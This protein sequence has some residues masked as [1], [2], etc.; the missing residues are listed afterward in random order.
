MN[1]VSQ[2]ENLT[3]RVQMKI[4]KY[5]P[6][7]VLLQLRR[8]S[9]SQ[10]FRSFRNFVRGSALRYFR[11]NFRFAYAKSKGERFILANGKETYLLST[12]D[13]AISSRLFAEG[14][15]DFY[16][17]ERAFYALGAPRLSTLLDVGAHVGSISIPAVK[18]KFADRAIALE[19]DKENYWLL[20]TNIFLNGLEEEIISIQA[21][22]GPSID[23]V[24]VR[25]DG[26]SN[27]GDHRYV[28]KQLLPD[29]E[30]SA[31]APTILLDDFFGEIDVES[32]LL[33]MDI[34]GGEGLALEGA[35]KLL[36]AG[37]P[38]VLE[39]DPALLEANGGFKRGFGCLS[40]YSSFID[41]GSSVLELHDVGTLQTF[42]SNALAMGTSHDLLF[43]ATV[44]S[45]SV[46]K[47]L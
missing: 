6:K 24:Y 9:F 30:A 19:P 42:Y 40:G 10:N 35:Q 5:R 47:W 18:R 29:H 23:S 34:Q 31:G 32:S 44:G 17:F 4:R 27:T 37:I 43:L 2:I 46:V 45:E 36:E 26:G 33:W 25:L 22:A 3:A 41:L 20:R 8:Q 15:F 1:R 12:K 14:E 16:K 39:F 11:R 13:L 38:V 28:L 21:A 7:Q